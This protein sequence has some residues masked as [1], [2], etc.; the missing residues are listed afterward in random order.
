MNKMFHD[1]SQNFII[2]FNVQYFQFQTV[3]TRNECNIT[4][5]MF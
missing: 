5:N 4:S 2:T 1:D 3:K